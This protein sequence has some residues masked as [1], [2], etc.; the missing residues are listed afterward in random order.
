MQCFDRH[1]QR[2]DS[3]QIVLL[4]N[5]FKNKKLKSVASA[6]CKNIALSLKEHPLKVLSYKYFYPS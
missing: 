4:T 5:S 1:T 3:F 2:L 6:F